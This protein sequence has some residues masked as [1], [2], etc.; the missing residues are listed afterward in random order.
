LR[1]FSCFLILLTSFPFISPTGRIRI[2][3]L[4][5]SEIRTFGDIS[6]SLE[7]TETTPH[8]TISFE[9][10][11]SYPTC[12]S[13]SETSNLIFVGFSDGKV[14]KYSTNVH[15]NNNCKALDTTVVHA[16]SIK[17]I[18]TFYIS[19]PTTSRTQKHLIPRRV[20]VL[21]VCDDCGVV[22]VWDITDESSEA[23]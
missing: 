12:L 8:N 14:T 21:L 9:K 16:T 13:V 17:V 6:Q 18:R 2:I 10:S 1:L 4:H 5:K 19:Q 7:I 3:T 11:F 22:S 23:R 20:L 15:G